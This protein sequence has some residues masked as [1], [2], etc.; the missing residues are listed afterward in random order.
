M[1][2]DTA[3]YTYSWTPSVSNSSIAN[4][5]SAGGYWV[6]VVSKSDTA[7]SQNL[8]I[9]LDNSN[10]P[11][12]TVDSVV[13]ANCLASNGKVIM[14]DPSLV[15]YWD[16]TETT[17]AINDSLAS[18]CYIVSATIPGV[19][20][21]KML[22]VCVPNVNPLK[23]SVVVIK[24]AK[25]GNK[26]EIQ[27]FASGGT[28]VYSN[29]L[30]MGFHL[31]NLDPGNHICNI[32]DNNT[33]CTASFPFVIQKDSV[34]ANVTIVPHAAKCSN[35][36][37][38]Y[39]D[40]TIQGNTYFANPPSTFIV[41]AVGFHVNNFHLGPGQYYLH[42]QDA[43]GCQMPDQLFAIQGPSDFVP[44]ETDKPYS[45]TQ[46]GSI[47]LN[48]SGGN[49]APYNVDWQDLAGVFDPVNRSNL[50]PGV[51]YALV[52]DSH[53]CNY[54][55]GPYNIPNNCKGI[56]STD[57]IVAANATGTYCIPPPPGITPNDIQ[58][59]ILGKNNSSGSAF[60]NWVLGQNGCLTYTASQFP[61]FRLDTLC[62]E[63][64]V[65]TSPGLNDT[66]CI[67][68]SITDGALT[69]INV[70]F[71]VQVNQSAQACGA[72]PP[73]FTHPV[74]IPIGQTALN[75]FTS[76]YGSYTTDGN[77]CLTFQAND[78]SGYNVAKICIGIFDTVLNKAQVIC[79]L[80]T[81][82]PVNG[83]NLHLFQ[84]DT[85][86]VGIHNCNGFTGICMPIPF[87]EID[88][89][90]IQDN[91]GDYVYGINGCAPE[92]V[93][94]Y[95]LDQ[96]PADASYTLTDW[97]IKQSHFSGTFTG[98]QGLLN[99]MNQYD[100]NPGW[101]LQNNGFIIGG[102]TTKPY[103]PLKILT[104]SGQSVELKLSKLTIYKRSEMQFLVGDHQM[105]FRDITTGC[106]DSIKVSVVCF[107]CQPIHNYTT[108]T[109]GQISWK[110]NSCTN[111]TLFCTNIPQGS[112][113]QFVIL[114]NDTAVIHFYP[115]GNNIAL[116]LDTGY[117]HLFIQNVISG[118]TYHVYI[119][120][121]CDTGNSTGADTL[122]TYPDFA[123]T[124]LNNP[125]KIPILE[126]DVIAG[127]LGNLTAVSNI[128]IV[129][130]PNS[131]TATIDKFTGI[132]TYTPDLGKCGLD[133]LQYKITDTYGS[134]SRQTVSIDVKCEKV[135]VF[136]GISPN[137]DNLNDTW[138]ILGIDGYPENEVT[139]Y[140]RWG[141]QVFQQKSYSNNTP[142]NG[143]WNG[144]DLPDG[145]YYYIITLGE[146]GTETLSGFLEILR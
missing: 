110:I 97:Q 32:I 94:A 38:G 132:L 112:L 139:V 49:G 108:N 28:G 69:T 125:V 31:T 23:D 133:S 17:G 60:G 118:C 146:K 66:L 114:D 101:T 70:P 122:I 144:R 22:Y 35:S 109:S 4:N 33:G 67:Y 81:I 74:L 85:L 26:G 27:I 59:K 11:D 12:V 45:C 123:T 91:G 141:N 129:R 126:N 44:N 77:G 105:V 120:V 124:T 24:D 13:P 65:S 102:D 20:C 145:T 47:T 39:I 68:I 134:Q 1:P 52:T 138:R 57:L 143:Q 140:N 7:C 98:I 56:K 106:P 76:P 50:Q 30:G 79:Y 78:I 42:I 53:G 61:G 80:P 21:F 90:A 88:K 37:D 18:K 127:I 40:F 116:Q 19:N 121:G 93:N 128:E 72:T 89:Y 58:Y 43:E 54:Q 82:L 51:Y 117:H 3:N 41:D 15:Y 142:W 131:G 34:F 48:L 6:K 115:C 136:N 2:D 46:E 107:N 104:G 5:V 73:N 16:N 71:N 86:S 63:S 113:N 8:L 83:C 64:K 36:N 14:S 100:P 10:A 103:G 84:E 29:N 111:D 99:L 75:G 130:P 119:T 55:I 96:L 9:L 137:G 92:V 62:V 25:C 135:I 95:S 87:N